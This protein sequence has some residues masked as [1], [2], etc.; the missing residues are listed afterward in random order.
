ML[1]TFIE[2]GSEAGIN[3]LAS[4]NAEDGQTLALSTGELTAEDIEAGDHPLAEGF[5]AWQ[6]ARFRV[7]LS[8]SALCLRAR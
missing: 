7:R 6:Q 1:T 2:T 5:A 8:S 3:A 4:M